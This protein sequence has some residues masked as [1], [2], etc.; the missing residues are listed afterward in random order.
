MKTYH[1]NRQKIQHTKVSDDTTPI[2]TDTTSNVVGESG[3]TWTWTDADRTFNGNKN[4]PDRIKCDE[5]FSSLFGND[6]DKVEKMNNIIYRDDFLKDGMFRKQLIIN[7]ADL[8]TEINSKAFHSRA[9]KL[10]NTLIDGEP[11]QK[12]YVGADPEMNLTYLTIREFLIEKNKS[13]VRYPIEE[14]P[15][16]TT[17]AGLFHNKIKSNK[18]NEQRISHKYFLDTNK[19]NNGVLEIRYN[20]N[21][22]LTNVKDQIIGHGL[23]S[24]IQDIV[25]ND[26]LKE[27]HYHKLTPQEQ[28]TINKILYMLDKTHFISNTQEQFN[29][30]FQILL[31]E[32][33]AGNNSEFVRHELK[34]YILHARN[35]NLIT[36]NLGQKMLLELTLS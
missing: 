6:M 16:N 5:I 28:N 35:I 1:L 13:I 8:A 4:D 23:K 12:I 36:R 17:S 9:D 34:Q 15:N 32:W 19:L 2:E 3:R 30:K 21:R 22:H 11:I 10:S 29:N 26:K 24:M 33:Q 20:K 18:P 27:D 25:Y 14:E 31:G 7:A